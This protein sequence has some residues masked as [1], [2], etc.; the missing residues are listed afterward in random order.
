M[1][2]LGLGGLLGDASSALVQDGRILAAAE[3]VKISRIA[4]SGGIPD[5]SINECLRLARMNR[6][7]VDPVAVARP[8]ARGPESH[9]HLTLRSEFPNADIAVCEHHRAH[10]ASAFYASPDR[11][12]TRLNSSHLKL[13]RMPSSA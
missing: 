4:R 5:A 8:F 13:S 10:A 9:L 12:S 7:Q 6:D 3:D 11:K 2:I 1:I